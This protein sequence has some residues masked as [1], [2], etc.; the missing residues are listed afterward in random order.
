V[1]GRFISP[2]SIVQAP[3]DPQTLNRYSYCRNNPL[4]Y[5]DPSGHIFGI[6]DA[7][8]IGMVL[9]GAALGASTSAIMGG[10]P[11]LGALTG[12]I[13]ATFFMGAHGIVA[14]KGLEGVVAASVHVAAGAASGAVNAAI[15]GGNP[16]MGAVT[17]GVS[18]GVAYGVGSAL[19][20]AGVTSAIADMT[21]KDFAIQLG[22]RTASGAVVGGVTSE[23]MG[24]DFG[25][26]AFTGAWTAG[27]GFLFNCSLTLFMRPIWSYLRGTARFVEQTRGIPK[28]TPV[29]PEFT[30]TRA[31]TWQELGGPR[32]DSWWQRDPAVK[33]A[34]RP[35]YDPNNPPKIDVPPLMP[36]SDPTKVYDKIFNPGG[37]T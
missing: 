5:T 17:S 8:L 24:G 12:A 11:L 25:Q 13:S 36:D 4:V 14:L 31:P 9:A 10:N 26:G 28:Q 19:Q 37:Y 2:D 34:P 21:P 27:Y 30:P 29:E 18:A 3:T 20:A 15:T 7:F 33:N 6:D 23:M 32:D 16:L 22:A 35:V 1:I